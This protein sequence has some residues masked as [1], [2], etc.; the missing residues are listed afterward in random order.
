MA[1][2]HPPLAGWC[3]VSGTED[4]GPLEPD[5]PA[6]D[7]RIDRERQIATENPA[8]V[9][10]RENPGTDSGNTEKR[11]LESRHSLELAL[12]QLSWG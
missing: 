7:D 5:G 4:R 6:N 1:P 9:S 8:S 12:K 3:K 11:V 2:W 10:H